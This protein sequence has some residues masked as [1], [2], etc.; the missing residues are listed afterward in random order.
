MQVKIIEINRKRC[1]EL[2]ELLP[3]A[4]IINGDASDQSL[5]LEEGIHDADALISL[6]GMDEENIII[7]LFAGAQGVNKI[8]AKVNEDNRARMVEGMGIDSIVSAKTATA[9]TIIRYIRARKNSFSSVNVETMYRLLGGQV[10][11]LEFIIK[12]QSEF[13]GVPLKDLKLKANNLIAC[14]GRRRKIII[15]NGDTHLEVGDSVIIV[16][17]CRSVNNFKDILK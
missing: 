14:I 11:A 5:L 2:C 1:E 7:S 8:V 13:V 10:E 16:T 4:T 6:T 3:E 9:D 12:K 15:P 17:K